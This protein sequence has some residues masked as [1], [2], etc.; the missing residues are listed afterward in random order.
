M[1]F[2]VC[3]KKEKDWIEIKAHAIWNSM[4]QRC[5]KREAYMDV[6]ICDEWKEFKNFHNWFREQ[7]INGWYDKGWQI[8]KDIIGRGT[9]IYSPD[10]CAFVPKP[11]NILFARA[12]NR[13]GYYG[14]RGAYRVLS[15]NGEEY[16]YDIFCA[17]ITYNGRV[18]Y[19][20]EFDYELFAFFS[21]KWA[22]E[23]FIQKLAN[24]LRD[25]LNPIMYDSLMSYRVLPMG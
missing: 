11:L 14:T 19:H 2:G 20:E 16:G 8:D 10:H 9:R 15:S 1:A 22:F 12:F 6:I 7:V 13:K 18:I 25:K 17:K 23:E 24:E 5:G 4:M 21:Y 3:M